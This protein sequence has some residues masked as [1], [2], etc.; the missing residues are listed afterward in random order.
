MLVP[1]MMKRLIIPILTILIIMSLA[2]NV[3]AQTE[4]PPV[5]PPPPP[6]PTP[7]SATPTGDPAVPADEDIEIPLV[8]LVAAG[9]TLS[10]IA[11]LYNSTIELLQQLNSIDDPSLLY[12][13]QELVIPGGGGDQVAVVHFV[14]VGESLLGLAAAYS[15]TV[16][17]VAAD[18]RL[19]RSDTLVAGQP[20]NIL[21]RTGSA[22][23]NTLTGVAYIVQPGDSL[24][25]IAVEHNLS[26]AKIVAVNELTFP[27]YL[28]PNQSLYLPSD[29]PY[30]PLPAKWRQLRMSP[31][32]MVQGE[33]AAIYVEIQDGG[34]PV[35][36][37]AGQGLHFAPFADGFL[38]LVGLDAFTEPGPYRLELGGGEDLSWAKFDQDVQ[39]ISGNYGTQ[40][41]TVPEELN[42]LLAPEVRA[43][44]EA[45][46]ASVFG[47]FGRQPMW[48]EIFQMPVN[49]VPISAG[50]GAA[51]SYNEG[52][53]EIFHTGVDFAGIVG[54]PIVAPAGGTVIY[55]DT[56]PL[57][58][59]SLVVDHG[60]GVMTA[61]YHLS[62]IHVTPGDMVIAGQ[63][64]AAGGST[65]LSSGPH[66]HWDLRIHNVPV[67]GLQWTQED[68]VGALLRWP[69]SEN[70]AKDGS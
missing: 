64:I 69:G 44:D 54:T 8:H 47:Q 62:E 19:V 16:E 10:S 56:L 61:Y 28:L 34:T 7:P 57:H 63:Q 42:D 9:E 27:T 58:G 48:S 52:P 29:D 59:N 68:L 46:L 65:G 67:N 12:V 14:Q 5:T 17:S 32:P 51:R 15:T 41:I 25:S 4:T 55:S 22:E 40:Y 20:L 60:L 30:Q 24:L 26:P 35:G 13:G 23:P 49:N 33:S 39:V 70:G 2:P 45:I 38:A 21:S 53:I 37:F 66:L 3:L 18:N 6:P 11:Q 50:Y 36:T 43:E 31:V 1:C